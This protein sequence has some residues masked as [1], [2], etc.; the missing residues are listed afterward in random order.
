[1]IIVVEP[2][3]TGTGLSRSGGDEVRRY[4]TSSSSFE[5]TAL[6]KRRAAA[7]PAARIRPAAISTPI[8]TAPRPSTTRRD[9]PVVPASGGG[10]SNSCPH[11]GQRTSSSSSRG[12]SVSWRPSVD[13]DKCSISTLSEHLKPLPVKTNDSRPQRNLPSDLRNY[14]LAIRPRCPTNAAQ[15]RRG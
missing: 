7:S 4:S 9:S 15:N 3:R 13:S 1:M 12:S 2:G 11:L 5:E 14:M 6:E 8:P 10:K